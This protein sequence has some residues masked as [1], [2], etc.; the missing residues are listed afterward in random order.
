VVSLFLII[1]Y[2][3]SISGCA[4]AGFREFEVWPDPNSAGKAFNEQ[5]SD[6]WFFGGNLVW[7][8]HR[9]VVA[10]VDQGPKH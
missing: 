6:L 10:E 4:A 5:T 2:D 8:V 7:H 3:D 9:P 1:G